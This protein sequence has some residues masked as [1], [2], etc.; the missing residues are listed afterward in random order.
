MRKRWYVFGSLFSYL[1]IHDGDTEDDV[2]D[3]LK[4]KEPVFY[5][6]EAQATCF[7]CY[8]PSTRIGE[9]DVCFQL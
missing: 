3:Q 2:R 9:C 8:A 4:G 6:I 7:I 5:I 1:G